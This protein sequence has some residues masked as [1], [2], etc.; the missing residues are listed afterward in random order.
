MDATAR[1]SLDMSHFLKNLFAQEEGQSCPGTPGPSKRQR[2][3]IRIN[4]SRGP[5]P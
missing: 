1:P 2:G 5:A 3:L 4:M